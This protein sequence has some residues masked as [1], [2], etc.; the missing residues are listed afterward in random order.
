MRI[1]A[2]GKV[3]DVGLQELATMPALEELD[4]KIALIQ[5]LIPLG[6]QAVAET[7]TAEVTALT[8]EWYQRSGGRPGAV[9]WSSQRG[10]VYLLDQKLPITYQRVRDRLRRTEIPLR[11]YQQ[12]R[13]AT[14]RGCRALSEDPARPVLSPV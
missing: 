3:K 4:A 5:A 11:T 10:S 7:L 13:A 12:L 14:G 6:L 8:G 2:Q 9:R 1:Q